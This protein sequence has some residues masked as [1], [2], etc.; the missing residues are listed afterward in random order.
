MGRIFSQSN[1]L[2][3]R[4]DYGSLDRY[5]II[6]VRTVLLKTFSVDEFSSRVPR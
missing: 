6:R 3:S 2:E 4:S 5:G 1:I